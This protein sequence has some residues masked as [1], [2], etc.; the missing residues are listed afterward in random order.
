MKLCKGKCGK[1]ALFGNWCCE[2]YHRCDGRR[3]MLSAAAK[4]RGNNG[5]KGVLSKK[6][7]KDDLISYDYYLECYHCHAPFVKNLKQI[8]FKMKEGQ[9]LCSEC[10]SKKMSLTITKI[11]QQN[12]DLLP[13]DKKSYYQRKL[14]QWTDQ[15][16][17]C[18]LCGFNQH[19]LKF[20]PYELHHKDN[21]SKNHSKENEEVVCCNC[22]YTT[23]KFRFKGRHHTQ[24]T[25]S[26]ILETRKNNKISSL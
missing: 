22:H 23:D 18:K 17:K 6:Y 19:G 13:Y 3:K 1:E 16:C 11:H 9:F 15:G 24:E 5:I 4:L 14:I 2:N 20:G 10:I 7:D 26:K 25:I 21:N 12:I 8:T